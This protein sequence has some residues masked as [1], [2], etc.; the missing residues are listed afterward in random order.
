[1]HINNCG[2]KET[3]WYLRLTEEG[4]ASVLGRAAEHMPGI[5]PDLGAL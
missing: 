4:R 1:M 3:E 5:V 2:P